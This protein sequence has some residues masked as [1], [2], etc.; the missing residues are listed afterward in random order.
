[1][2][3]GVLDAPLSKP[4]GAETSPNSVR[5]LCAQL[6]KAAET[7]ILNSEDKVKD[8]HCHPYHVIKFD[9]V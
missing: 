5:R 7:D 2:A 3:C 9:D 4:N 1:M 6:V 8:R